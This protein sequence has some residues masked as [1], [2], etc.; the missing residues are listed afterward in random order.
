MIILKLKD[1]TDEWVEKMGRETIDGIPYIT[2]EMKTKKGKIM[3]G[4]YQ[5][6]EVVGIKNVGD[7]ENPAEE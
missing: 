3:S 2:F 6:I 4:S 7:K 1:G 5:A